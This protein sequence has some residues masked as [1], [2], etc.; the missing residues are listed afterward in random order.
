MTWIGQKLKTVRLSRDGLK[1]SLGPWYSGFHPSLNQT[2]HFVGRKFMELCSLEA[3]RTWI[4][5][6][7]VTYREQ[8]L[9]ALHKFDLEEEEID[10]PFLYFLHLFSSGVSWGHGYTYRHVSNQTESFQKR[11]ELREI[12]ASLPG[13]FFPLFIYLY[14]F[15]KL[16]KSSCFLGRSNSDPEPVL[17]WRT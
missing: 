5:R 12:V 4:G 14:S 17:I 3:K 1:Q 6:S 2:A 15:W 8:V 13:S 7:A 9:I 16:L 10:N 11:T